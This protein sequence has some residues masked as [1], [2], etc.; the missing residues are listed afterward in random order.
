MLITAID[1]ETEAIESRPVY[2]PKPV[3]VAICEEGGEPRYLAWGHPT[4]NNITFEAARVILKTVL[5]QPDMHFVFHNAPFDCA[6]IQEKMQLDVP[7]HKVHDTMLLAFLADPFGELRLKPLC[8]QLLGIPPDERD[9]VKEW[10]IRNGVCRDSKG[11]G[12]YISKAPGELVGTYAEGDVAR[13]IALFNKLYPQIVDAGMD[14][15]YRNE[16]ALMPHIMAME[17]RGVN[18]DHIALAADTDFYFEKLEWLDEEI[19]RIVG[20]PVDVDS[21]AQLA[22]AIEAA[23]LSKGFATTPTGLRSTSKESLIGAINDPTLLGHLLV[24]GSIATCLRTFLQPWLVQYQKHGRLYMQWNQIRNYTDTGARTGRIS[25]SPNLQNIPVEWEGLR[26]QLHKIGYELPFELPSVRKYI[27]PDKGKIFIGRDYSAQEM[28]LLAH[29]TNGGMLEKLNE[30][31]NEDVHMIAANIA[32]ITRKVAKTLGFAVLYGAGVG[33]IAESL[34]ITV[35]EATKIKATYLKALPEIKDF[36]QELNKLGRSRSYT[37]TIGG[38]HYYVQKPAVVNGVLKTFEY[39][40]ANYKIQGSAADQTK[41]AMLTFAE[42]TLF[43]EL[44][45]TVHDQLVIQAPVEHVDYEADVLE[46]AMNGAFQDVLGYKITS[47][48][49][50]GYNF[51]AL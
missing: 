35:G 4:G 46:R 26:A 23:G 27:I 25:S 40:L 50:R 20:R 30:N 16:L 10:L 22:D 31:P 51:A 18:L 1:F 29:F 3:G 14:T 47:D 9:A 13:T 44:V 49:S 21:N 42:K 37:E 15:A 12:A 33:R 17:K 7:W 2:L 39:K 28:K 8:E 34:N 36:Q 38:R 24:R 48:E 32:G 45:L 43:G 5:E 11:W 41:A 19:A 6:V